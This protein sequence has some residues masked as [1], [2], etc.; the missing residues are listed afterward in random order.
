MRDMAAIPESVAPEQVGVSRL[1]ELL[2][3]SAARRVL[4]AGR[5]DRGLA[6][7]VPYPFA[8]LVGQVDMQLA[9]LLALINPRVGGVLLAGP[10]GTGKTTAVRGLVDLLPVVARSTCPYGCTPEAAHAGG[11][12]AICD[13][14]ADKLAR[15]ESITARDRMRLIE[16]PLN[17]R[18]ED[19]IGGLDERSLV[20]RRRARI[21]RGLLS[22]ADQN[23]LYIDEV[24]LLDRAIAD[25]IL[26]AAAQGHFTVHRGAVAASYRARIVLIGSMNPEEGELRPQLLDR[27]GLRVVVRGLR[28]L[29]QRLEVY[30][31][32]RAYQD[33]PWALRE[34]WFDD[35]LSMAQEIRQAREQLPQVDLPGDV[36][37]FGLEL[38][39]RLGIDSQRAELALFEAARARAAADGRPVAGRSDVRAVAPLALRLRRS[40]AIGDFLAVRSREDEEFAALLAE[41]DP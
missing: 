14:C 40:R 1:I 29:D 32:A 39:G 10:R 33:N 5:E 28:D 23:L 9:L 17:A 13:D 35:T 36:A 20:E 38:I 3:R 15:G 41:H 4:A 31:R 26:D 6:E 16:L 37:R 24:N 30:A 34:Q 22:H 8:A 12:G 25:A 7:V 11:L 21:E 2:E 27:F 18:L 19:V